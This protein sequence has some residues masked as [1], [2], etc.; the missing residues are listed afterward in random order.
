MAGYEETEPTTKKIL[1]VDDDAIILKTLCIKLKAA[2]YEVE[3]ALDG[4]D[5]IRAMR[6]Q[7]PDLLMLD[8]NFPPDVSHGGGVSWDGFVLMNWL[9]S[10]DRRRKLPVILMTGSYSI[11]YKDRAMAAGAFGLFQKPIDH[12][13]L[14]TV[15]G[16][17][18]SGQ[19]VPDLGANFQI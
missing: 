13:R 19:G 9:R 11:S 8:I 7:K 5:A 15:I 10:M 16:R 1:V 2:G 6:E 3:V 12:E 4:A 17:A 14:V 18:L